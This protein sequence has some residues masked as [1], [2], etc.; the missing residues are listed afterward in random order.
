MQEKLLAKLKNL[1]VVIAAHISV[2]GPALDL[3]TYLSD[4]VKE[5]TFIGHALFLW[6]NIPSFK[7]CWENGKFES[8]HEAFFYRLPES[9][10][11]IK[12]V[13]YTIYWVL[14][15]KER[16]DLFIGS[17]NFMSFIGILL[18]WI[19]KVD[20]VILYTIDYV[21][22]RFGNQ[23]LNFLYRF[24]DRISLKYCA[25]VWNVSENIATARKRYGNLGKEKYV[26]QI[27]VPL[28]IWYDRIP[29]ISLDKKDRY[30]LIFL[31]HLL[32]KQ[33]LDIVIKAVK[34]IKNK[35]PLVKLVVIGKGPDRKRLENLAK[36]IGVIESVSFLGFVEDHR[37]V[38]QIL[39]K[40]TIAVATYKPEP[41][42]FT[43]FADPGKIKSYLGAGL[44]II[45]TDVPK[46]APELEKRKCAVICKYDESDV[47]TKIT[48]L[49]SN[50]TTLGTYS[51]NALRIAKD[52][53]WN[54]VFSKAMTQT[55]KDL[56]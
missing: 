38:E 29:K 42:S 47:A 15:K 35:F 30:T 23:L 46:I 20:R 37:K 12:D 24:F 55:F 19:G 50:E 26:D 41:G 56:L 16:I 9:M 53:D 1:K 31:G 32:S 7:R 10:R 45:L 43:Y 18:K 54:K 3:E 27:T 34:R 48:D 40:C 14:R 22:A 51:A 39:A 5:L 2:S 13:F 49:L 36:R 25:S 44:P 6:N 17:D 8:K 33:G 4:K 21:P 11:H 28:G 52:Y